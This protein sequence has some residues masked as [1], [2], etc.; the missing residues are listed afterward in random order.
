MCLFLGLHALFRYFLLSNLTNI[1]LDYSSKSFQKVSIPILP[2]SLR[3]F[4]LCHAKLFLCELSIISSDTMRWMDGC[5]MRHCLRVDG[6]L[7]DQDWLTV[8]GIWCTHERKSE[9]K[10]R[11]RDA[12][13]I[14]SYNHT[15][16]HVSLC[17][18]LAIFASVFVAV[19][20]AVSGHW[21]PRVAQNA[22]TAV[23]VRIN[24]V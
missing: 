21:A 4:F 24:S 19:A 10:T 11:P 1:M 15:H 9:G 5:Y 7:S 23:V 12:A 3:L 18:S 17:V 20:V 8:F 6:W 14:Y 13:T 22:P 16:T 2:P